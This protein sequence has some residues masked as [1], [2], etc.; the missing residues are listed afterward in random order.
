LVKHPGEQ[1]A[2]HAFVNRFTSE[3]DYTTYS[4]AQSP[5]EI[6]KVEHLIQQKLTQTK[7]N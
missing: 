7:S 1:A 6:K 5:E 2:F 3:A 4:M